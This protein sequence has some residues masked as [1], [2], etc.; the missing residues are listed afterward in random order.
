[1]QPL[2]GFEGG[3]SWDQRLDESIPRSHVQA[4]YHVAPYASTGV[5]KGERLMAVL[6]YAGKDKAEAGPWE[7]VSGSAG[8][9]VLRHGVFGE[10]D[11]SH[12]MLPALG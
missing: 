7:I 11:V 9:W 10:W 6:T 3:L 2:H 1:L 4:P 5:A 12:P 8:H